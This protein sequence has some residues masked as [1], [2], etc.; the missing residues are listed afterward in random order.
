LQQELEQLTP[1][2]DELDQAADLLANFQVHWDDCNGD[3][4]LQHRLVKLIIERVYVEDDSVVAL[5]LK[6]DCHIVLGHKTNE[7]T[8]M[9]VDPHIHEWARRD[10]DTH[11]YMVQLVPGYVHPYPFGRFKKRK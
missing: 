6:S 11:V 5:T 7:P 3:V 9:E 10:L 4:E 1:V 8:E 2:Q